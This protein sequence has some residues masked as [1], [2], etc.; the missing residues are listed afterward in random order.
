MFCG[1]LVYTSLQRGDN[2]TS[3]VCIYG[4]ECVLV[5]ASVSLW[6]QDVSVDSSAFLGVLLLTM[7]VRVYLCLCPWMS[8]WFLVCVTGECV[9]L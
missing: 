2:V 8:L 7:A 1:Y 4:C 6:N 9:G 3:Q 5:G